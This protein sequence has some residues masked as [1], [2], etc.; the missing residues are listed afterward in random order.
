MT[1]I[2]EYKGRKDSIHCSRKTESH[3]TGLFQVYWNRWRVLG[4]G[5]CRWRDSVC[6]CV[7]LYMR[8]GVQALCPDSEEGQDW[9]CWWAS[10]AEKR[11]NA[12]WTLPSTWCWVHTNH[13]WIDHWPSHFSA[14]LLGEII[15][16][17][18]DYTMCPLSTPGLFMAF[19]KDQPGNSIMPTVYHDFEVKMSWPGSVWLPCGVLA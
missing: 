10:V 18:F 17:D 12:K 14:F 9:L 11:K 4:K 2:C 7:H 13:W 15:S 19:M 6:I 16:H 8:A 5:K 3:G 1:E